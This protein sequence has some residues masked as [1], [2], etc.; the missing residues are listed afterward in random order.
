MAIATS[1]AQGFE[2]YYPLAICGSHRA[3]ASSASELGMR[4][5]ER[6]ATHALVVEV[7]DAEVAFV[8]VTACASAHAL[9]VGELTCMRI[10]VAVLAVSAL[11]ALF[12]AALCTDY[13]QGLMAALARN[14]Q[15]RS[16]QRKVRPA[17]VIEASRSL[18]KALFAV[19][20]STALLGRESPRMRILVAGGA[21]LRR[22][23]EALFRTITAVAA[24]ASER[25]VRALQRK[26][27]L[28]MA[29]GIE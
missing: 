19:A 24:I 9:C 20:F 13:G 7:Q 26:T 17:L 28:R 11:R 25:C 4:G 10:A 3:M 15:V 5:I 29:R 18:G 2:S 12:A 14:R 8:L 22:A 23:A 6:E 1:C 16:A 21:R 27:R